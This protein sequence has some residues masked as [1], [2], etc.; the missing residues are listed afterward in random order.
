[1]RIG[2]DAKRAFWNQTGL[3]NYSRFIINGLA[4]FHPEND[5]FLYSPR[6]PSHSE[7]VDSSIFPNVHPIDLGNGVIGNLKRSIGFQTND[8]DI[9]HGLSNELPFF[10][11]SNRTKNVV[12]VHDLLFL[13]YPNF[14][15]FVDR[16]IY[17]A[18]TKRS[19]QQA[20]LVIAISEQTKLDLMEYLQVP[21]SKIQVHYQSCHPQFWREYSER[22]VRNM[23]EK[24]GISQPYILQV[25]TLEERKNALIT[26][27]A[28]ARSKVKEQYNLVFLGKRTSYCD[29]LY[30]FVQ[31]N[32][33]GEKVRFIDNAH[34]SDFPMFY[35]GASL[36]VYP[37]LFEGFGIPILEAMCCG[38]PVITSKDGCFAEVG[39]EAVLYVDP[40][41]AEELQNQM[42]AILSNET[43]KQEH[44]QLGKLQAEKFEDR[45]LINELNDIYIRLLNQ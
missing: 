39:G 31:K 44:I 12:S 25:G 32:H 10:L 4:Q 9:F 22:E 5:Y 23:K 29:R 21:E 24:Y 17:L 38:V 27:Q 37:S 45:K 33:L 18:K 28:F 2:F 19:C 34:F 15:P 6:I 3:G 11:S 14:Y 8:L 41:K 36:S 35:R 40:N 16:Q 42:D 7:L 30:E 13:R 20:D 1:M 43:K 26:L